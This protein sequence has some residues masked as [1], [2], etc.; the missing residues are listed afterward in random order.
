MSETKEGKDETK[1]V[2]ESRMRRMMA[3]LDDFLQQHYAFRYNLLTERTE[4]ARFDGGEA[5][6]KRSLSYKPID[7]RTM[8]GI[9]IDAMKS[10]IDCWDKDVKRCIESDHVPSYHPF[11]QYMEHLPQWDGTDRVSELA[12][13]VSN[14]GLWVRSFHRW[15]LALAAQWTANAGRAARANSVAPLLVSTVQGMGKSTFCRLLLPPELRGYFTE[16]FD[17]S[18]PSVAEGKLVSYGL[19]NIDEFDRIPAS[20]IP[21]LKNIMQMEELRVRRAYRRYASPL[22][23]IASFIGTSNRRDLLTDLSGS[24]RF[25]CVEVARPI[26]CS[27]P[28]DHAQLYAQLLHELDNG[29]RSW[30]SKSEEAAIE[31]ANRPFYRIAPAG[32][33][34]ADS[35]EF[36][37]AGDEDARLMSALDIYSDLRKRNLSALKDC[38][39]AAFSR[40]LSQLGQRVHTRYGNGYWMKR[41][42]ERNKGYSKADGKGRME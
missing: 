10:G 24:R 26:D 40:M 3:L 35:F 11:R 1:G 25:I 2:A 27:T 4:Y 13:R 15:M 7:P 22:P 5:T 32:E 12:R 39:C 17:L 19:V 33:L 28:I 8:N 6:G 37:E 18:S 41:R 29:E 36:A 14:D 16:S 9:A 34:L 20:R 30:F 38:S 23:R 42:T 31:A 21:L